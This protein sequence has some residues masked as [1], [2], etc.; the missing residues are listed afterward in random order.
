MY[1]VDF[2]RDHFVMYSML[3][4]SGFTAGYAIRLIAQTLRAS[5]GGGIA[6]T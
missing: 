4:A 2:I 5:G 3:W 1:T 6:S